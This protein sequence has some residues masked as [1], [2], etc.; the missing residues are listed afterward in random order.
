MADV[1][2]ILEVKGLADEAALAR[3]LVEEVKVAAVPGGSFYKTPALAAG[4]KARSRTK[5]GGEPKLR[6]CFCKKEETLS[7]ALERLTAYCRK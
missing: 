1:G 6:F 4:K 5:G 7:L 3:R 2:E